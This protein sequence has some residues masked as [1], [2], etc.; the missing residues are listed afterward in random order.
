MQTRLHWITS[1]LSVLGGFLHI[2]AAI[3]ILFFP[4]L[5]TCQFGDQGEKCYGQS[6]IQIGG[7]ILGYALLLLMILAGAAAMYSSYDSNQRRAYFSRWLVV[8]VGAIIIYVTGFSFGIIFIPGAVLILLA[9]LL[10]TLSRT[11]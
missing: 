8:V 7:N 3:A 4:V 5:V 1:R 10:Q 11:S 9:T 2:A 6:Y